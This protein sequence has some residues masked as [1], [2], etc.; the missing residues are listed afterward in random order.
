MKN[1]IVYLHKEYK[2]GIF[3]ISIVKLKNKFC[4]RIEISYGW[5]Q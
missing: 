4:L 2:F 3:R 1:K 5:E